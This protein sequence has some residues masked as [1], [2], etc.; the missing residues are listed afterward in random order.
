MV[1]AGW[2]LHTLNAAGKFLV[3]A[4]EHDTS[5]RARTYLLTLATGDVESLGGL[6]E[7]IGETLHDHLLSPRAVI[8]SR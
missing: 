6:G 7:T 4:P 5:R 3:S 1:A 8:A 2:Q